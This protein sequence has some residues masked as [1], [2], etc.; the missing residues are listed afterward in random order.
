MNALPGKFDRLRTE[1]FRPAGRNTASGIVFV[2]RVNGA[3]YSVSRASSIVRQATGGEVTVYSGGSP[4]EGRS[5]KFRSWDEEKKEN[6]AAFKANRVP[7]LV[8]TKAFGMGI[9]KPNIRYTVHF[10]MPMSLESFY[11]EA[12]RAGRDG[13][14]ARSTVVFSEYDEIRSDQLTDPDLALDELRERFEEVDGDRNTEDD[15]TRAL[16]FH[17]QAFSGASREVDAVE[18][19]IDVIG[20][21]SSSRRREIPYDGDDDKKHKEKAIYQLLKL[22]VVRDYEVDFGGKKFTVHT[23]PFDLDGSRQRLVEYV[24]AT[25]PGKAKVF[26]RRANAIKADNPGGSREAVL[27]LI[28]MLVGFTYDEIERSRR[29]AIMEAVQLARHAVPGVPSRRQDLAVTTSGE[30][31]QAQRGNRRRP[32]RAVR[33]GV[34]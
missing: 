25:T 14:P 13:K 9:D 3:T 11:Q 34:A 6:A 18:A 16:W 7:V 26:V 1:F 4:R 28:G 10:G 19:L 17:L 24:R 21:L 20:D 5:D 12:G 15:V 27:A 8:A 30:D 2:S 32:H 33:L 23:R 31:Q 22:G 29:R